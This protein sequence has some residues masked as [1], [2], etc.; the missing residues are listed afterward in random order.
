MDT[1]PINQLHFEKWHGT[2]NDFVICSEQR[3]LEFTDDIPKLAKHMCDRH[4]GIGSDGLILLGHSDKADFRQRMW[5]PDGSQAEMCGNGLR[6]VGAHI[7]GH[8]LVDSS[9]TLAIETAKRIVKLTFEEPEE[10]AKDD[11]FWVRLGLGIPVTE[12]SLIPIS[13][14]GPSPVIE[15]P[16]TVPG[17]DVKL[18]FTAINFG[19]PHAVIFVDDVEKVPL[20]KWGPAIENFT[21]LFPARVNV[22]IVQV[23]NANHVKMRVW[24]RG[25]G[26]TLSCGS[27]VAAI[28]TACHL[29]GKAGDKLR[30]DVPGGSLMTEY[31]EGEGVYLSGPAKRVYFGEWYM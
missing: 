29:T 30:V 8:G 15:Q 2:G 12:R 19:N 3:A 22:E 4:F 7:L 27:G 9:E 16:L 10:W 6:C 17:T 25:A 11:E 31:I 14:D 1:N 23:I 13:G 26:I 28:Q 24:E 18:K 5:N 20:T 21:E